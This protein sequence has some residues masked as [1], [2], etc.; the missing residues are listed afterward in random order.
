M[1]GY[2]IAIA[3]ASATCTQTRTAN[4]TNTIQCDP[5]LTMNAIENE[6]L[7]IA[8]AVEK[9]INENAARACVLSAPVDLL[10]CAG[11]SFS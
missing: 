3:V 2:M 1:R 4:Y 6:R 8:N 10:V 5:E 7:P 11:R 9:A